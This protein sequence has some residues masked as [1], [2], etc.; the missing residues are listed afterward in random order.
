M[1]PW[2]SRIFGRSQRPDRSV[3]DRND[4]EKDLGESGGVSHRA[5][6]SQ[7][8][9]PKSIGGSGDDENDRTIKIDQKINRVKPTTKIA[10]PARDEPKS[11]SQ[12]RRPASN[13]Q[14][15]FDTYAP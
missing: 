3:P 13:S 11:A 1:A 10:W 2:L 12:P 6:R 15:D 7:Q 14:S 5:N 9:Q 8:G 4:E